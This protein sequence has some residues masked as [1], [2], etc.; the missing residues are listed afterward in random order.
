L[1]LAEGVLIDDRVVAGGFEEAWSDP[2][3][4]DEPL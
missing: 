3:F 2:R 1:L 4:E